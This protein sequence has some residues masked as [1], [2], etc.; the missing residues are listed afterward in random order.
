MSS[1][2]GFLAPSLARASLPSFPG[3]PLCPFTHLKW[4]VAVRCFSKYAALL[5]KRALLML[6]HAVFSHRGRC[7]VSPLI[8]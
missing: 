2:L 7:V 6:I 3:S 4:V 1:V 8:A 5:K